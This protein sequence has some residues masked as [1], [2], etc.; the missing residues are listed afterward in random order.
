MNNLDFGW[1]EPLPE[2]SNFPVDKLNRGIYAEF[3]TNYLVGEADNGYVLNLNS[4]WGTGKTYFL[5]RWQHTI[6]D[7]HPTV[8]VD[9]WKQDF[10]DDPLLAVVSSIISQLKDQTQDKDEQLIRSVGSKLWGFCKQAAPEITKAVV[11]KASGVDIE[12]VIENSSDESLFEAK[13][14]AD[15]AGKFMGAVIKDHDAKLKSIDDFKSAISAFIDS[16]WKNSGKQKQAFIFI[17]ELDRC[18]PSYAVEMLEVIKHFF[19]MPNVVFVVATDTEQL[20]HAVKAVYGDDFNATLY[21]GRFFRRRCTLQE[22]ARVDFISD[23]FSTFSSL[24]LEKFREVTWPHLSTDDEGCVIDLSRYVSSVADTYILSLRDTEQLI[25]KLV[26]A[27]MNSSDHKVDILFLSTLIILHERHY[28]YYEVIVNRR[29]ASQTKKSFYDVGNIH[30][31]LE[32]YDDNAMIKV[33]L[34]Y[35]DQLMKD[36]LE[37]S[38]NSSIKEASFDEQI[39]VRYRQLLLTQLEGFKKTGKTDHLNMIVNSR[40]VPSSNNGHLIGYDLSLIKTNLETYQQLVELA[41]TFDS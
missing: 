14:F 4:G 20:Q 12:Q 39:G 5:K 2:N 38:K 8:Y 31:F 41:A 18:R 19:D 11:K 37:K 32:K 25:D 17:D 9:A 40:Q 33:R 3:L 24:K 13:D 34:K 28:D 27:V 16:A 10:S 6:K 1:N 26:A 23:R 30:Y 7:Q 29:H 22:Q 21:L 35:Q 36:V 15:A